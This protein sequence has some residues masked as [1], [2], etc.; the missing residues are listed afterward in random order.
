MF[1]V[2]S[3]KGPYRH[4]HVLLITLQNITLALIGQPTFLCDGIPVLSA[5]KEVFDGVTSYKINLDSYFAT[6]VF[7][8]FSQPI[9][10]GYNYMDFFVFLVVALLFSIIFCCWCACGCFRIWVYWE[11]NWATYT[12]LRVPLYVPQFLLHL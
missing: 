4:T 12:F 2:S 6:M 8:A 10:T 9:D 11:P 3:P 5:H 1:L 7:K